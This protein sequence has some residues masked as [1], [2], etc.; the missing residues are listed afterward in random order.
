MNKIFKAK[1][2]NVK[3][4]PFSICNFNL[5]LVKRNKSL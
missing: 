1:L 5:K 2:K 4:E 3:E